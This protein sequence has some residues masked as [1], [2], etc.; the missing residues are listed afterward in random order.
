MCDFETQTSCYNALLRF[1]RVLEIPDFE[2][3]EDFIKEVIA[4]RVISRISQNKVTSV[5]LGRDISIEQETEIKSWN[6]AG[7]YPSEAGFYVNPEEI[8]DPEA[9]AQRYVSLF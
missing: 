1:L 7:L 4:Q 5:L 3:T 8:T 9:F 2:Y 6:M